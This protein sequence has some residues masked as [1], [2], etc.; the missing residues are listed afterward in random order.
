MDK[1]PVNDGAQGVRADDEVAEPQVAVDDHLLA[2][3]RPVGLQRAQGQLEDRAD[4]L[5]AGELRP[6]A[7][8]R[9]RCGQ[10]PGD[11]KRVQTGG[12]LADLMYQ[13]LPRL[14]VGGVAQDA[15]GNRLAADAA[16]HQAS[17]TPQIRLLGAE[18][19]LWH[20]EPGPAGRS[21]DAGFPA[22]RAR[23]AGPPRRVAAQ[24][25]LGA[26]SAAAY[27][28]EG[29]CLPGGA[30]GQPGQALDGDCAEDLAQRGGKAAFVHQ[31]AVTP[32]GAR[33]CM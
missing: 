30:A 19:H 18:Q 24:H 7:D 12:E 14:A 32:L 10:M 28:V 23:L 6:Q 5:K 21:D 4:L 8:Q 16:H 2:G 9:V 13:Q 29:P 1:F 20:G 27:R 25:Q 3:R 33:W 22:H 11:L 15:A 26:R 17:R 31:S